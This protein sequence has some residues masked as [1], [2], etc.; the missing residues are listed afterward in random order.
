MRVSGRGAQAGLSKLPVGH[1]Q[2]R[3]CTS[4]ARKRAAL[5]APRVS[6]EI[7]HLER[8]TFPRTRKDKILKAE[9]PGI[10]ADASH[11][12]SKSGARNLR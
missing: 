8:P 4:A 11:A 6:A 2:A 3:C 1:R 10:A 7:A 12:V 5:M 9:T